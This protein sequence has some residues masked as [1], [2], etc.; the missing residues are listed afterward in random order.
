MTVIQADHAELARW[1][2]QPAQIIVFNLGY[3]PYSSSPLITTPETTLPA[4]DAAVSH[5]TPD[6]LLALACYRGH[7]GGMEE[8]QAVVGWI[9]QLGSAWSVRSYTD[10]RPAAPILYHLRRTWPSEKA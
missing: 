3:L 4:L 10:G 2:T 9:E 7:T 5:L 6:G 1:L 8:W